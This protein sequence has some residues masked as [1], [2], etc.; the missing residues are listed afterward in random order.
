M[1]KTLFDRGWKGWWL[2]VVP[3]INLIKCD[4]A[5]KPKTTIIS[6]IV[7]VY[8]HTLRASRAMRRNMNLKPGRQKSEARSS[9]RMHVT[10]TRARDD[11]DLP[12][13]TPINC[14][15]TTRLY[16]HVQ[17]TSFQ[18]QT[19]CTSSNRT[20]DSSPSPPHW[21]SIRPAAVHP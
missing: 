18:P 15:H 16:K 20:F 5:C 2:Y 14:F 8:I 21:A 7:D 10:A 11:A 1:L 9:S 13:H 19:P 12:P 3:S 6:K 17:Y 4:E